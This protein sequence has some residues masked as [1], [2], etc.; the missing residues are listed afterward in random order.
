MMRRFALLLALAPL[1]ACHVSSPSDVAQSTVLDEKAG[2]AAE[3]LYTAA[4]KVGQNLVAAG[5]MSRE[6]YRALD[7]RAY[8]ALLVTRAAYRAGNAAS[9]NAAMIEEIN[10][11]YAIFA[12]V[13]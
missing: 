13:K 3:T 1:A 4:S 9:Y 11:A 5:R 10:A 8:T 2:I 6:T 7:Q 12:E